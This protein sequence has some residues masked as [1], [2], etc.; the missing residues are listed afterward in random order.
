MLE[1]TLALEKVLVCLVYAV[2]D[3]WVAHPVIAFA[4]IITAVMISFVWRSLRW[5]LEKAG[6]IIVEMETSRWWSSFRG[7]D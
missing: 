1:I 7:W 3:L 6:G 5:A 2:A 4:L